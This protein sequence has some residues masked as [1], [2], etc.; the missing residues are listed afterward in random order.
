[1]RTLLALFACYLLAVTALAARPEPT[2][3]EEAGMSAERLKRM[4]AAM[5]RYIDRG[6]VPGTVVLVARR[7]R[8]VYLNAQGVMDVDSKAPMRRD[9]IFLIA[10]MTKPITAVALMMLVEEGRARHL[11]PRHELDKLSTDSRG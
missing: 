6:E 5:Q 2:K 7:G 10:S 9:T 1:L 3:P 4:T 11:G 8:L